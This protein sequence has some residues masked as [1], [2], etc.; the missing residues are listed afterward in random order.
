[1]TDPAAVR[2]AFVQLWG[3]LGQFWGVSPTT[4]RV[5]AWFLARPPESPAEERDGEAVARELGISRGAVSM[6]CRELGDW[7]LLHSERE[8]GSRRV[9][10][11]AETDLEK[12]I[13]AI[14]A[15]RKRREWD[16]LLENVR[17]WRA[18]LAGERS[19]EARHLKEILGEVEAIV[20]VVDSMAESFLKGGMVQ[21]LGLKALV[22][23][24][25]ARGKTRASKRAASK[26][27]EAGA[28]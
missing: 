6:A 9:S 24:A 25:R 14:V 13:R 8:P 16:P 20:G 15:T 2:E 21:R 19:P 10:Y 11:R 17:D 5:Y 1:M 23:A 22:G 18:D 4:A 26:A 12:T 28:S 7:G 27:G 3:R